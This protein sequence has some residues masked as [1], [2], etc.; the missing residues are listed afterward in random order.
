MLSG[1]LALLLSGLLALLLHEGNSAFQV[2]EAAV[3]LLLALYPKTAQISQ[4]LCMTWS[5]K[6]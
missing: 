6:L 4:L 2:L 5:T 3:M 1:L